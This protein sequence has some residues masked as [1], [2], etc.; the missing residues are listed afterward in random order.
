MKLHS[1]S[2]NFLVQILL[3]F[4]YLGKFKHSFFSSTPSPNTAFSWDFFYKL[5]LS[6][7]TFIAAS[8]WELKEKEGSRRDIKGHFS[9]QNL[10]PFFSISS[11]CTLVAWVSQPCLPEV[12]TETGLGRNFPGNGT[13][14]RDYN[15][16]SLCFSKFVLLDIIAFF[17]ES[18]IGNFN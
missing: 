14:P 7:L 1:T 11:I 8:L 5:L 4:E 18:I 16:W 17:K 10:S 9:L 6:R 13:I 12:P 15:Q 3:Y 2:I